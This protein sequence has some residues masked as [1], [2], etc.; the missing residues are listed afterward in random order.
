MSAS[1]Q[2]RFVILYHTGYGAVHWDLMLEEA[3]S[4]A[5]WRLYRD[6]CGLGTEGWELFPIGEH[7]PAYLDYEGPLS[8]DRGK[9][10]RVSSGTYELL[11]KNSQRWRVLFHGDELTGVWTIE[12]T[13]AARWHLRKDP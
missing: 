7:R 3:G 11:E 6:P 12:A 4:L 1:G 8:G 5:T 9:V 10:R 2:K 13:G